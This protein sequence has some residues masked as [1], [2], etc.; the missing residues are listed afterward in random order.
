MNEQEELLNLESMIDT[1]RIIEKSEG[2]E[3]EWNRLLACLWGDGLSGILPRRALRCLSYWNRKKA[4]YNSQGTRV[5]RNFDGISQDFLIFLWE[6]FT[7]NRKQSD[8]KAKFGNAPQPDDSFVSFLVAYKYLSALARHFCNRQLEKEIVHFSRFVPLTSEPCAEIRSPE[9]ESFNQKDDT[10]N[11][12][13]ESRKNELPLYRSDPIYNGSRSRSAQTISDEDQ[14]RR[15]RLFPR[16][17]DYLIQRDT[18]VQPELYSGIELWTPL[19]EIVQDQGMNREE[20]SREE[21]VDATRC[22]VLNRLLAAAGDWVESRQERSDS[23]G[24][25][26]I[27]KAQQDALIEWNGAIDRLI[28]KRYTRCHSDY[29]AQFQKY[30]S[31]LL[32][33]QFAQLYIPIQGPRL[34]NLIN[35]TVANTVQQHVSRYKKLLKSLLLD[36]EDSN[37]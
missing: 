1:A 15:T 8:W 36:S 19:K 24:S 32:S 10:C 29:S 28:E 25:L 26:R 33:L 16:L 7:V 18:F 31:R 21:R 37:D 27:Q 6:K 22:A 2:W 20:A 13:D 34:Q 30:T 5:N 23:S 11:S 4:Y 17:A 35:L 9:D 14:L 3:A 12:K